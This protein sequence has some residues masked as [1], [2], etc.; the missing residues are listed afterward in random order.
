VPGTVAP[1]GAVL[2]CTVLAIWLSM[3]LA[4]NRSRYAGTAWVSDA[5]DLHD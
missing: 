4:S 2:L 5:H 1:P 3:R